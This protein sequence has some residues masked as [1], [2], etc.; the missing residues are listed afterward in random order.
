MQRHR[1]C[2][3]AGVLTMARRPRRAVS[4]SFFHVTNR[5]IRRGALFVRPT[6]YRAFL[7][8]LQ[9]GLE[10]YP[11]RLFAF[12]VLANHWHLVVGPKDTKAL[13][14]FMRWVTATHAI[15]WHR[16]RRTAGQG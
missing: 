10:R 8:V 4:A 11:V 9:E 12:C 1:H 5:G 16:H 7:A 13:S 3:V 14:C 6:D 2:Y 15:R